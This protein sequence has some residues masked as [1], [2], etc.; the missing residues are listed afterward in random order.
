VLVRT[1]QQS[2]RKLYDVAEEIVRTG[3]LPDL[4]SSNLASS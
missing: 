2:N 1:S 3:T 4:A